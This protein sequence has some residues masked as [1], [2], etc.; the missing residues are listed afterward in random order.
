MLGGENKELRVTVDDAK[1]KRH[2]LQRSA[3]IAFEIA[4]IEILEY[5]SNVLGDVHEAIN[6]VMI[7]TLRNIQDELV[8]DR[9]HKDLKD[10]KKTLQEQQAWL[11]AGTSA[12][13]L[14]PEMHNR[15]NLDHRHPGTCRWILETPNYKTWRDHKTPNLFYLSGEGG[16][17]KS[18]LVSTIIEDLQIFSSPQ[19]DSEPQV[20]YFFCKSR[21]NA[22]QYGMKIM[23][24]LVVQ[25]FAA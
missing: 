14:V 2:A 25:L 18:Y 11:L 1:Q 24:H 22:T 3:G 17:G 9:E 12:E 8:K 4:A 21:E 23:L 7:P 20:L 6:A 16:Y 15:E 19:L 5:D 10:L 13:L